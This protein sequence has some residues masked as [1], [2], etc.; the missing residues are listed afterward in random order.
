MCT[1]KIW[2]SNYE[3]QHEKTSF[4]NKPEN[5]RT[6][7]LQPDMI[8]HFVFAFFYNNLSEIQSL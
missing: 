2:H 8:T 5:N 7:H 1:N 3:H 4:G 6:A